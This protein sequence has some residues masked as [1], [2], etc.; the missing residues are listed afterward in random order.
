MSPA[1]LAISS[2][3]TDALEPLVTGTTDLNALLRA[4]A[5]SGSTAVVERLLA[6]GANVS[7][8]DEWGLT[9]L[10]LA[11]RGGNVKM[12]QVL[13]DKAADANARTKSGVT[14]LQKAAVT[15]DVEIVNALLAKGADRKIGGPDGTPYEIALG[16]GS[17][18]AA[19]LLGP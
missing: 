9:P 15:G 12:V 14:P 3:N 19:D 11:C 13:L 10:H 4:A 5:I 8:A 16:S 7:G 2:G 6:R 17:F 18:E 1:E